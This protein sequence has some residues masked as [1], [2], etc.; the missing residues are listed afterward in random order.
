VVTVEEIVPVLDPR[1]DAVVLPAWTVSYVSAVPDGA[2]P[3]YAL[4]YSV[5]DNDYYS[6]WDAISRDRGRFTE[7]LDALRYE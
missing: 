6:R 1:P 3:S 2:H 5:R 7:W 4:G